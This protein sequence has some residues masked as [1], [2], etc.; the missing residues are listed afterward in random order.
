MN[1]DPDTGYTLQLLVLACL[2]LINAFFAAAEMAIVSSNRNKIKIHAQS[3]NKKA[4]L[5]Q[6]LM[7]SPNQ[8][9]STIQIAITLAGFL[10]SAFAAVSMSDD[11]GAFFASFGIPYAKQIAVVVVTLILSYFT[12][13]LGELY[14]KRIGLLHAEKI[15][16][17]AVK[18]IMMI[19]KITKPFV[20]ILSVSLNFLLKL[21]RQNVNVE[22]DEFSE[23]EVK[24][25]LEVGRDTG[26]LKEEGRKMID[27]IFDFD[28]KLAYE[29][30]TPRTDVFAIDIDDPVEEFIDELME[31]HYSRIPVYENDLDNI[32]GV[33]HIKDYFIRAKTDGF[34]GV[35]ISKIL[36]KP[37]FV[38]ATKNIDSLFF[39]LQASKNQIAIL[40]DEYGGFSGIV[41][42]EDLIEEI[43]GDIEDEYD[44]DGSD[45][46]QV[47][48]NIYI[49][50]GFS[51]LDD[52][53]EILGLNL[54][55][56]DSETIGGFI[57]DL[58]GEIP[59]EDEKDRIVEYNNCIFTI[60][61]VKERRI[62]KIKIEITENEELTE[63][64]N[65]EDK[66]GKN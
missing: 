46:E 42:T 59:D 15:A 22:G 51:Y 13:V 34:Y 50:D 19:S 63:S 49:V 54:D 48:E 27:S 61:S 25:M 40:I 60:L 32:I 6:E 9:L 2:I 47:A 8:F 14:P 65:N 43:V 35:N 20:W 16:M 44:D 45:I 21:T 37:Y 64:E 53:N 5:V 23:D 62:E 7:D 33:L 38:P 66:N 3:G 11:L 55:S 41:T 30:M 1:P 36:R 58:L 17:F 29:I 57:I 56:E 18:P 28:D 39:D 26:V 12:L 31:L 10:S 4:V 52:I 24:S